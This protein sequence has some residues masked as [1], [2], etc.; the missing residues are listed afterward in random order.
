MFV[1]V[2]DLASW[3][4]N[5][6]RSAVSAAGRECPLVVLEGGDPDASPEGDGM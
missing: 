6:A 1:A 3:L 5:A 4:S 2:R